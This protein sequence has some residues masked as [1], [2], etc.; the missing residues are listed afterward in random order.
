MDSSRKFCCVAEYGQGIQRIYKGQH[1]STKVIRWTSR[2]R[3]EL[4]MRKAMHHIVVIGMVE[5]LFNSA[6][7]AFK[8]F[9]V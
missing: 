2:E 1:V 6:A 7:K 8:V 9:L 4:V 3:L 5:D